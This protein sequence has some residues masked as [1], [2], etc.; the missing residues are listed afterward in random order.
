LLHNF[1]KNG[2]ERHVWQFYAICD[3][4]LLL[5]VKIVKVMAILVPRLLRGF[6]L[7]GPAADVSKILYGESRKSYQSPNA[8]YDNSGA[9]PCNAEDRQ[10]KV[11]RVGPYLI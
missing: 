2:L 7:A 6:Q 9:I 8:Q 4:N 10:Y 11:H 5:K 3:K 1:A